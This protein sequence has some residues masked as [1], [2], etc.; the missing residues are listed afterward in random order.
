MNIKITY[1]EPF[2]GRSFNASYITV[3]GLNI[4]AE[5]IGL[6]VSWNEISRR[7]DEVLEDEPDYL[8]M[9]GEA[10]KIPFPR[11]EL[12]AHNISNGKDNYGVEKNNEKIINEGLET[13]NTTF[14]V[15][16][17]FIHSY[18]AGQYLCNCSYYLALSKAKST[19]VIFIHVPAFNEDDEENKKES[20][21]I[22]DSM[23]NRL[24]ELNN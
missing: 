16:D 5:K 12:E 1:F 17:T 10:G 23:I 3:L 2:G 4:Y 24:I 11:L 19:K 20:I 9:I 22:V 21:N 8:F 14:I 18:D 15:D 6:P 13:L 7:L